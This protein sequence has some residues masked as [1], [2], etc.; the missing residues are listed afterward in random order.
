[1]YIYIY[2]HLGFKT[3]NIHRDRKGRIIVDVSP[4]QKGAMD[5]KKRIDDIS[6]GFYVYF[7]ATTERDF[8]AYKSSVKIL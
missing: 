3:A 6:A 1:M 2:F 7:C 8:S 5:L 4:A